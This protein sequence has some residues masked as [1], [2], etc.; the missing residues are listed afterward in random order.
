ME[1]LVRLA[2][3]HED[4]RH[5]ELEALAEIAGTE[6]ELVDYQNDVS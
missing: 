3:A 6:I 4:F 5:A 1:F 2:Q